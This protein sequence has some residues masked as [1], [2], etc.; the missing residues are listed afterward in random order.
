MKDKFYLGVL[1]GIALPLL[2]YVFGDLLQSKIAFHLR[3]NF[4]QIL[5]VGVNMLI[6]QIAIKKQFDALAKG[7]LFSTFFYAIIFAYFFL[8]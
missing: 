4:F 8:R 7:V 6:F 5:C 1:Y 3:P 2:A